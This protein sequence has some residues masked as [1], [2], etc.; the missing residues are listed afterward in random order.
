MWLKR[1]LE[2]NRDELGATLSV[3]RTGVTGPALLHTVGAWAVV[4]AVLVLLPHM[5]PTQVVIVSAIVAVVSVLLLLMVFGSESLVVC[6]RALVVGAT[7]PRSPL[8]IIRY[9]QIVP[10]SL[11]PVTHAQR[12]AA[13]TKPNGR[14][15]SVRTAVGVKQGIHFVGPEIQDAARPRT[16][17][18]PLT[19]S[20]PRS[21]D[22]RIIWL[23]G[24]GPTPPS[25]VTAQIAQA[26]RR[27][28][29]HAL[30]DATD[31]APTR[32]LT[33][34]PAERHTLLPGYPPVSPDFR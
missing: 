20:A 1:F 11:V 23:A 32:A 28:G 4:T 10:G 7:I 19:S 22:G 13:T 12:Y 2:L 33:K 31:A 16:A 30:A 9:E 5:S 21:I 29:M 3:H 25:A 15:S 17:T 18:A 14:S 8:F 34:N 27:L 6:E 24:T 26:T